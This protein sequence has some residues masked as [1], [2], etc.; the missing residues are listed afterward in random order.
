MI[1]VFQLFRL[2][3]FENPRIRESD[4]PGGRPRGGRL[5]LTIVGV[6][7]W[8]WGL[9]PLGRGISSHRVEPIPDPE[10]RNNRGNDPTR[11]TP[12]PSAPNSHTYL[13]RGGA[14][15][16]PEAGERAA[17]IPPWSAP[18]PPALSADHPESDCITC[19]D[20]ADTPP[21][22]CWVVGSEYHRVWSVTNHHRRGVDG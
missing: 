11:E 1:P 5:I 9:P 17:L 3:G 19:R 20:R 22:G 4:C 8:G 12:T 10:N 15:Y 13:W 21:R 18:V 6:R 2:S 16:H 7:G 14:A